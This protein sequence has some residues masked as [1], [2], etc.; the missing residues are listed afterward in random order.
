MMAGHHRSTLTRTVA[1]VAT[2][3][4]LS[5]CGS[6]GG[7]ATATSSTTSASTTPTTFGGIPGTAQALACAQDARTLQQASAFYLAANGA[8]AAS[9]DALVAAGAIKA[10][11]SS[12]HGYVI[13]YDPRSGKVTATGACT[14]P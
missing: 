6:G 12:T 13:T 1:I 2:L 9:I 11:P 8:A 7:G 14:Y 4:V 10:A 3:F 5:G